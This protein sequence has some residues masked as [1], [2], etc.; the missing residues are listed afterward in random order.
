[1]SQAV[2]KSSGTVVIPTNVIEQVTTDSG[3]I[4]GVGNN[5]NLVGGQ[6][7]VNTD[8]GIRV[9]ANPNGSENGFTQLTNRQTSTLTT[10]NATVT[11]ILTIPLGATPASYY[12]Y[13][14][15]QAFNPSTPAGG[16]YGFSGGV[17][18]TGAAAIE[19]ATE[20]HDEFEE[21]AFINADIFLTVSGNNALVQV[22]GVAGLT[23]RWNAVAQ[24]RMVI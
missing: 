16:T 22:Q 7:S 9:I 18:T 24:Y 12:I 3:V 2:I 17:R 21:A 4:V 11:T 20:Y 6:T 15:V 23:I 1:M 10:T 8:A 13:G 19:I 5:I 14:N